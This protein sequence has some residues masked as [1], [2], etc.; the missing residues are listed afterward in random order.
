V[1]I[2]SDDELGNLTP[3]CIVVELSRTEVERFWRM[4]NHPALISLTLYAQYDRVDAPEWATIGLKQ[5]PRAQHIVGFL[6]DF[7]SDDRQPDDRIRWLA[8]L[9]WN[10][11]PCPVC[12]NAMMLVEL[13]EERCWGT[14]QCSGCPAVVMLARD[15]TGRRADRPL[16][17]PDA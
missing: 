7:V 17:A 11:P 5:D 9:R 13:D 14:Y 3:G 12:A 2:V 4:H 16:P 15:W 1:R 10:V 6:R 8:R